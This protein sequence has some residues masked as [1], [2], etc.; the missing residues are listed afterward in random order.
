MK[1]FAFYQ[2]QVL[3]RIALAAFACLQASAAMA[4]VDR[5]DYA[6]H[7][8]GIGT[9][10]G[11]KAEV[12]VGASIHGYQVA[13]MT[14]DGTILNGRALKASKKTTNI[15]FQLPSSGSIALESHLLYGG[16]HLHGGNQ[17]GYLRLRTAVEGNAHHNI[18]M[19]TRKPLKT[20]ATHEDEY[21]W[22]T[23]R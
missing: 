14:I 9:S 23:A 22:I 21:A 6:Y 18:F 12:V 1:N 4:S 17:G 3:I 16:R 7:C 19:C 10:K 13:R 2:L 15:V 5:V 8:A 11:Q 20:A